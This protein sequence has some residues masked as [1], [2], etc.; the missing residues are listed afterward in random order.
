MS[1]PSST[2]LVSI[3][4]F[5]IVCHAIH[6]MQCVA[7]QGQRGFGAAHTFVVELNGLVLGA[8]L[9][10]ELLGATAV[11][12]VRLGKDHCRQRLLAYDVS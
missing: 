2:K 6:A 1:L 5:A 12:A 3:V 4:V 8:R 10:E 11:R 9:V 7:M